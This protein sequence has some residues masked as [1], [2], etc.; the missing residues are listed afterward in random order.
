LLVT[1][2]EL[3]CRFIMSTSTFLAM[4]EVGVLTGG[5]PGE[6]FPTEIRGIGTGFAAAFSRI[7]ACIGTFLLPWSM[8]NLGTATLTHLRASSNPQEGTPIRGGGRRIISS[9][10][11]L[12]SLKPA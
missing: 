4:I 2:T 5:Y 9:C 7:G 8:T 11:H 12:V 3:S 6:V 1:T 10:G